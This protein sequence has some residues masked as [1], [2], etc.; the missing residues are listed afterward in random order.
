[1]LNPKACSKPITERVLGDEYA[2]ENLTG[3]F[4]SSIILRSDF[5]ILAISD[6][7]ERIFKFTT[8]DLVGNSVR[9]LMGED[10]PKFQR[11]TLDLLEKGFF[12]SKAINT[13]DKF[14]N[15]VYI[16]VSGFYLGL[17]SDM[18]DRLSHRK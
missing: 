16:K 10:F 6:E 8:G 13:T 11:Y 1:M 5:R 9:M 7:I 4:P 17:L 15:E 14:G 3:I 2:L 18:N 12:A